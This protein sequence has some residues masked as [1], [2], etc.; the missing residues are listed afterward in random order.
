MDAPSDSTHRFPNG[1][2]SEATYCGP[3]SSGAFRVREAGIVPGIL[4]QIT[5]A[6]AWFSAD[7]NR[8]FRELAANNN[9]EWFD[10]NRERYVRVVKEPFERF[11]AEV[12]DRISKVDPKVRITP[13][14]AIFRINRDVR[15]SKEKSPYKLNRSA[16]IS[17]AGRKALGIP[18]IYF[19]LG[20]EKVR[21][22]GGAYMPDKGMLADIRTRIVKHPAKFKALYGA[23][24]F[25][26]RFGTILGD[27]NKV[28]PKEFKLAAATEPLLFNKQ[29]YYGA[30]LPA[31]TVVDPALPD[32]LIAHYKAMAP[33]NAFLME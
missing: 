17:A 20:P 21:I 31:K 5:P 23:K 19:E 29:F 25:K 15:F 10:A 24:D 18:G 2:V 12:I 1:V 8:F 13:K 7:Y 30:E 27:R 4:G 22:Y 9:K 3:N 14:E 32:V 6:M 26:D 11:T 33:M 28:L 16:L